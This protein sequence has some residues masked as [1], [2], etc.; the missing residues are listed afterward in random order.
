[1]A[2]EVSELLELREQ[3]AGR[4]V[5]KVRHGA[6]PL[7]QLRDLQERL[8]LLD[9]AIADP[10]QVALRRRR[11][12]G[13][14]LAVVAAVLSLG[15]LMPMPCVPFSLEAEAGALRLQMVAAGEF[16]PKALAGELRVDG[17]TALE[18]PDPDL[19]Q[20]AGAQGGRIAI[21]AASLNLRRVS[22]PAGA[23]ID[24][25]ADAQAVS[26]T[27]HSQR[28]PSGVDVE[29]A[30]R[31]M[32]RFGPA[33]GWRQADFPYAEWVRLL[34]TGT[35]ARAPPPLVVTLARPARTEYGW[36]ELR[37]GAVRFVERTLTAANDAAVLSSLQKARIGL[38][39]SADEV[40]LGAGDELE[41]AGLDLQRCDV[42]LGPVL[43]LKMSG[44]AATLLTRTGR[45]EHSLKPSVLY[46]AARHK[47]VQL[48]WSAALLLW[49]IT[50]WLQR[51]SGADA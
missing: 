33:G 47:T 41:L 6:T 17:Y 40:L 28:D 22:Y 1:M 11:A 45:F 20:Q 7:P 36:S 39:A 31:T 14:A 50:R 10:Q 38:P 15:A 19:M 48:L 30:G 37:P 16:G 18:S 25:V 23:S 9:A 13:I 21:N 8:R 2:N 12:T 46:Y 29:V 35:A 27:I 4:F 24:M 3:I 42:L 44:T 5:A 43:R 34:A 51:F 26:L 32:T 49:G